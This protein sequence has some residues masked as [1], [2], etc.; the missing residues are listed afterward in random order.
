[1]GVVAEEETAVVADK[2]AFTHR[3]CSIHPTAELGGSS[4]ISGHRGFSEARRHPH[5]LRALWRRE[6][7]AGCC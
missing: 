6:H 7:E 3:S 1:V 4:E 2:V 5:I